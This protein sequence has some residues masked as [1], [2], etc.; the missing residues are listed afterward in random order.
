MGLPLISYYPSA[1]V[2]ANV[3][4]PRHWR[5]LGT[6]SVSYQL[7]LKRQGEWRIAHRKPF[8][9]VFQPRR[10]MS[11]D[12]FWV[13]WIHFFNIIFQTDTAYKFILKWA[14]LS[15]IATLQSIGQKLISLW[16]ISLG[17][18][19]FCLDPGINLFCSAG[20][21]LPTIHLCHWWSGV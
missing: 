14:T 11:F 6:E 3:A 7:K 13:F 8:R 4:Y 9:G 18:K 5:T 21:V 19:L 16:N 12:F 10:R 15:N 17:V 2:G 1:W 20:H